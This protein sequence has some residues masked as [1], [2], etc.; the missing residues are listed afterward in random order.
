M[1]DGRHHENGYDITTLLR[2]VQLGWIW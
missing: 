1:T 2:M